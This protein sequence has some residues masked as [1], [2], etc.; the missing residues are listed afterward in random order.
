MLPKRLSV[1]FFA[2]NPEVVSTEAF[3]PVFQNWIQR[4]SVPGLL[5]DVADYSHVP[6]GPG[7]LIIAHEGDYAYDFRDGRPGMVYISKR[8]AVQTLNELLEHA[9]TSVLAAVNLVEKDNRLNGLTFD[10]SHAEI[11]FVD[12]LN[13]PN[14]AETFLALQSQIDLPLTRVENDP[15]ACLTVTAQS[16]D[17]NTWIERLKVVESL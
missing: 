13:T 2:K 10:L 3:I 5:I 11:S 17:F 16:S 9:F 12:R 6:Q 1:K 8:P 4:R 14:T 15:R 7:I